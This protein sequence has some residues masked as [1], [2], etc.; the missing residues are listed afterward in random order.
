MGAGTEA[1]SA[2][3][4]FTIS[5]IGPFSLETADGT[6]ITVSSKR[7]QALLA[8]LATSAK[9]ERARG[10]LE[11]TLW[12]DRPA[13]QAKSSLRKELSN[14]RKVVNGHGAELLNAD[15]GLIWLDMDILNVEAERTQGDQ[16]FL[17]GLDIPGEESFEDWLREQ[18]AAVQ[19]QEVAKSVAVAP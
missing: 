16:E 7:G 10:W 17:E 14:L 2:E 13:D 9:G 11:S 15:S 3:P 8:M 6:R 12:C 19:Q 4:L 18:R 5:L 1:S